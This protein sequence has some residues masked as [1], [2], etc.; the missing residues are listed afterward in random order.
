[1]LGEPEQQLVARAG[2]VETGTERGGERPEDLGARRGRV[3]VP[4]VVRPV[5]LDERRRIVGDLA[6]ARGPLAV[7]DQRGQFVGAPTPSASRL[8]RTSRRRSGRSRSPSSSANSSARSW[9]GCCPPTAGWSRCARRR[10]RCSRRRST[11]PAPARRGP[12]P[13]RSSV[14]LRH[15]VQ[16]VDASEQRGRAPVRDRRDLA[17]LALAA[18]ER[19]AEHVGRTAR[20]PPPSSPRSRWSS[21]G[22]RRRATGR[23][24]GRSRSGRTAG[25]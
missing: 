12:G 19:P 15:G 22:T 21:P 18:V 10:S 11:G 4:V 20:R 2:P 23:P 6:G 3:G 25:R 14:A 1:M 7:R 24:G 16:H 8:R 13:A 17:G 9:S 5:R